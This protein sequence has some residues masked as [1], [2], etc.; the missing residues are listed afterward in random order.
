ME[1]LEYRRLYKIAEGLNESENYLE[2]LE[3]LNSL[4]N[5]PIAISD[6]KFNFLIASS[7]IE[8]DKYDDALPYFK[9]AIQIDEK[10]EIASLGLYITWIKKDRSDKAIEEMKRYLDKYPANLY[11]TTL[12]E[13]LG[14]INNGYATDFEEIIL[15]LAA[16]NHI[17]H[18]Q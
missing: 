11:R 10:S 15:Q 7:L 6:I 2:A 12:E 8:L 18:P 5:E 13:L 9:R 16:K 1:E 3:I 17:H 14:D 4:N